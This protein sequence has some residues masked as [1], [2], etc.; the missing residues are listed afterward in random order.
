M[1]DKNLVIVESP[2]KAK[3]IKK[4]L[5]NNYKVMATVGHLR[6]L[7]KSTMGVDIENDF[8]P[9]Y[10]NVRGKADIINSL[11]KEAK[12]ADKVYIATDPDREGEAIAWHLC[13]LIG[14]DPN[15]NNR[16]KFH[17][18]T[19]DSVKNSIKKPEAIDKN[20]VDSQQA[21]RVLDRIVGY[22][23]SP[24]LWKKIKSGL[25]AGRVQSIALRFICEREEEIRKFVPEEF[26]KIIAKFKVDNKEFQAELNYKNPDTNNIIEN[27][28]AADKI[29]QDLSD[30]FYIDSV[31]ESSKNRY[32]YPPFTTSTLQQEAYK[33]L[34]FSTSKT[35]RIAQQIYEGV[36]LGKEGSA[37]LITYMRTDSTRIS[38]TCINESRTVINDLF[39]KEYLGKSNSY[40]KKEKGSQDAHEGIR[41]SSILRRPNEIKKYLS[42][43]Q[44]KLYKLIWERTLASQMKPAKFISKVVIMLN[45]GYEFRT[46]GSYLAF[47]GFT[48][49]YGLSDKDLILPDLEEKETIK[50][51]A[52]DKSQ[53]FTQAKPR[54]TEASLVKTLEKEGIGRPS[55]YASIITNILSRNYVELKEKKFYTTE[56]GEKVN[57]FLMEY[58]EDVINKKFTAELEERLDGI[59]DNDVDWKSVI[60]DFYAD[61]NQDLEKAKKA[62][63]NLKVKDMPT[64]KKCPECG[65][66]LVYKHGRN[67]KFIGCSN[68]PDC[69]YTESIVKDTHVKCPKCGSRIIEKVSQR[70]KVFY[71]CENYPNCDFA[72]WDKPTGEKCPECGSLLVHRKNRKGSITKCSNEDCDYKIFE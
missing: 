71:G 54:Y 20:L 56:I 7:P 31:K 33:K 26:W 19:K 38:T 10:I 72:L 21:R 35:M 43:D 41:P 42:D 69:K 39:G 30:E 1:A 12:K 66:D 13:N 36:S 62:D 70:G 45:K 17:E 67:G 68:F 59:A 28:E 2:T 16:V 4:M 27:E 34:G 29:L 15:E 50:S 8:E 32:P 5:G 11:K 18:I 65:S 44:Y 53:H 3:T 46:S 6:D 49:V 25:S 14:I 40:S 48:K 9:K 37:G 24:L 55:T 52:I 63:D 60:R 64:G 47:D 23:I 57:Q 61:F 22:T 58:F 51:Q